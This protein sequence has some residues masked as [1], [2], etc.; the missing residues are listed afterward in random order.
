VE[1]QLPK[2]TTISESY[3]HSHGLHELRE[4]DINAPLPGTYTGPGT[5]IYPY[6]G[7]GPI[8]L[9]ES[10]GIFNQ[11][12]LI[13]N[14][15]TQPTSKIS[16]NGFYMYGHANSNTDGI[17]TL[18][19]NPYSMAGEYGPS[20][21]DVHHRAFLGG[22][23]ATKWDFRLSPFVVINSGAPFNVLTGTD[24]YGTTFYT[25]RPGI[26]PKGST[27]YTYDGL[28]LTPDPTPDEELLPRNFGRSPGS[29]S[30]NLRLAKT[31]GF[32]PSRE[33]SS[34]RPQGGG[35]GGD[36][37]GGRGGPPGAGMMGGGPM[38]GMF[39]NP[40]TNKRY[41]LTFS[42]QARNLLN[43]VNPGPINGIVTSPLFG[44]SNSLAGGFGAF[45]QSGNNRRFEL[46]ARF[47]F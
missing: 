29:V 14:V 33:G 17:G 38:G 26:A 45:S 20:S 46:Q 28:T 40:T 42:I 36:H 37:G 10:D 9:M 11:N 21:L 47:Q 22:S 12:Q 19:A 5:G 18:P 13:T 2:N 4:Q 15:R 43:H 41:N 6:G 8:L 23:I 16:L 25:A 3:L 34:N 30:V 32:G 35:G 24:P 7:T 27:P 39:G 31:F 44:E 1:R